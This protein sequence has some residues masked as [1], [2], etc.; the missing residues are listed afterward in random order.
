MGNATVQGRLWGA[1]AQ[2]WAAYV[3]QVGLPPFGAALDAGRVTFGTRLLDAGCGAGD[4][5]LPSQ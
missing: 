1:H 4:F 5:N 2:N 3:E